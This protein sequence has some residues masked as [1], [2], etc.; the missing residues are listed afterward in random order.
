MKK[1]QRKSLE[2]KTTITKIKSSVDGLNSRME[3]RKETINKSGNKTKEV[4]SQTTKMKRDWR[5]K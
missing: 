1:S 2:L 4:P 3:G 5:I